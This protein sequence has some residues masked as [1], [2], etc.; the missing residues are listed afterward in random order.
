MSKYRVFAPLFI[1]NYSRQQEGEGWVRLIE[2]E[3]LALSPSFSDC[4]CV[5]VKLLAT[6]TNSISNL[7]FE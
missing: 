1:V 2:R 7:D 4:V 5:C 6:F 3:V